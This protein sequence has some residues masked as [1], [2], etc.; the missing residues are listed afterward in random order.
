MAE[1]EDARTQWDRR[2]ATAKGFLFGSDPNRWLEQSAHWIRPGARVLSIADGEGRNGVWLAQHGFRVTAFDLSPIGVERAREFAAS[3][4]VTLD[5]QIASLAQ[6]PW[7]TASF[8]AVAAIFVQF[9]PPELRAQMFAGIRD[10]LQPGGV[11]VIEGYGLRQLEYKTG[12]PGIAEHLYTVP[13]LL[14][15]FDGWA[16]L[17]SRDA[18]TTLAEGEGHRGRSHVVSMVLR[19]PEA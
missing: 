18:D 15:A 5:L 8:D 13:M 1:F 10:A 3:R 2:F 17:A 7:H 6:W 14:R 16:V 11:L 4:G 12:G 9:A 19:K